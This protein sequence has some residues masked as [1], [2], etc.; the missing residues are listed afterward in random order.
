MNL[1]RSEAIGINE[2]CSGS[3]PAE[4]AGYQVIS[5]PTLSSK[6]N[7][8]V[9]NSFWDG[10]FKEFYAKQGVLFRIDKSRVHF[11][12]WNSTR[13]VGNLDTFLF[14]PKKLS[15]KEY[16]IIKKFTG[17]GPDITILKKLD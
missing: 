15:I 17:N 8:Y 11:E 9:L 2:F 10:P 12:Q 6:L 14:K 7:Y 5:D 1:P 13:L 3:S 16:E 4:V